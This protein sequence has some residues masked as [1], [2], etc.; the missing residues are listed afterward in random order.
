[1]KIAKRHIL[2]YFFM[3]ATLGGVIYAMLFEEVA[4]NPQDIPTILNGLMS[5]VS[6][7]IGFTATII[8]LMFRRKGSEL[9]QGLHLDVVIML[10]GFV[11]VLIFNVY[12]YVIMKA[13][14][15]SAIRVA[16][17]ALTL[18]YCILAHILYRLMNAYM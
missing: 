1:M 8:A 17:T 14:F 15:Q 16:F 3:T 13:D 6:I 7:M 10:L 12:Y 5:S 9:P 2:F 18:S 4:L 11:I